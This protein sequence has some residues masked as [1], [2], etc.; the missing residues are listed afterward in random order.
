VGQRTFPKYVTF[1]LPLLLV[2]ACHALNISDRKP[3]FAWKIHLC[4]MLI[5][6]FL[7]LL[8]SFFYVLAKH[9]E[10]IFTR[11]H[12]ISSDV[13]S[14]IKKKDI[15]I[16][17]SISVTARFFL[18]LT[19]PRIVFV[20]GE[21]AKCLARV[22][23]ED[24]LDTRL[25]VFGELRGFEDVSLTSVLQSQNTVRIEEFECV[26]L[27]SPDQVATIVCSSGSS[28]LP[29]G[30]EISHASMINYMNHV[31]I[32][33]LRGHVSMWTP[34]M[35]WYCGLFIVIKAILDCSKNVIVPDSDDD[36]M[37]CHFIEKYEAGD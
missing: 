4:E 9:I 5:F 16:F 26:K 17:S 24:N 27:T 14:L 8:I 22:I 36:E 21:S 34:S 23:K 29:K 13:T 33:D 19:R 15:S 1:L 25:V 18:S 20:N 28:G 35:R 3:I 10:H 37:L 2:S 30:T 31:K 32:H 6:P 11:M 12:K 7:T